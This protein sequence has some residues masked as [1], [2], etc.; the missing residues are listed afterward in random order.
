MA[1]PVGWFILHFHD[2]EKQIAKNILFVNNPKQAIGVAADEL[3]HTVF[4]RLGRLGDVDSGDAFRLQSLSVVAADSTDLQ[5]TFLQLVMYI[6]TLAPTPEATK[7]DLFGL[8]SNNLR[9][10]FQYHNI[11]HP[12]M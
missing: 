6:R 10:T 7:P 1:N 4:E 2:I 8:G 11:Y 3:Q 12:G 9:L 5:I